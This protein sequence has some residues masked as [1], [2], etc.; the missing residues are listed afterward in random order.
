MEEF[1]KLCE[2]KDNKGI[3]NFNYKKVSIDSCIKFSIENKY[4]G[5]AK[6]LL[7]KY[8]NMIKYSTESLTHDILLTGNVD[9]FTIFAKHV[10]AVCVSYQDF[11]NVCENKN[12]E[13]FYTIVE[14][15]LLSF[16]TMN[17]IIDIVASTGFVDVLDYAIKKMEHF[18]NLEYKLNNAFIM[19][20]NKGLDKA[21]LKLYNDHK[22]FIKINPLECFEY[23][24]ASNNIEIMKFSLS[25]Q[26]NMIHSEI[27]D[28]KFAVTTTDHKIFEWILSMFSTTEHDKIC[29]NAIIPLGQRGHL[30]MIKYVVSKMNNFKHHKLFNYKVLEKMTDTNLDNLNVLEWFTD[31]MKTKV[32]FSKLLKYSIISANAKV[33]EF[34]ISKGAKWKD[35]SFIRKDFEQNNNYYLGTSYLDEKLSVYDIS[36]KLCESKYSKLILSFCREY[37]LMYH[38]YK[39]DYFNA[40]MSCNI[41][42]VIDFYNFKK[43]INLRYKND[44][45]FKYA[46]RWN[47]VDV[48]LWLESMISDYHIESYSENSIDKWSIV[49]IVGEVIKTPNNIER[50]ENLG[51]KIKRIKGYIMC[52]IC[53]SYSQNLIKL[54]PTEGN[55]HFYC[56]DC[57]KHSKE[58]MCVICKVVKDPI[59]T[60]KL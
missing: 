41:Q 33:T 12:E 37:E 1:A 51:I 32:N 4:F 34:L 11:K 13:L 30:D 26:N 59:Y 27:K 20:C 55:D 10:S 14:L 6:W 9:L 47:L 29:M 43:D 23:G 39:Y 48:A 49:N 54:C 46:C 18:G 35:L 2:C 8:G 50:L 31:N 28:G 22:K 53:Y 19:L 40:I 25:F 38:S 44:K 15:N 56:L 52:I 24:C 5:V 7:I 21:A 58:K 36:K 45:F 42:N 17:S 60:I 57:L 3:V 16:H